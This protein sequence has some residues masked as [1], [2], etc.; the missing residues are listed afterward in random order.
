MKPAEAIRVAVT[1]F[2]ILRCV[3]FA[4]KVEVAEDEDSAH[5]CG[6]AEARP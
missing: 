4:Q 6:A 1:L 2:D 3:E 5:P